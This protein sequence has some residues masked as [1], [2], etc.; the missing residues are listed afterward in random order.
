MLVT[1]RLLSKLSGTCTIS[2]G[3]GRPTN[4]RPVPPLSWSLRGLPSS[5]RSKSKRLVMDFSPGKESE[6][7]LS[8]YGQKPLEKDRGKTPKGDEADLTKSNVFQ[9]SWEIAHRSRGAI[10]PRSPREGDVPL[11]QPANTAAPQ[12]A[13]S[14]RAGFGSRCCPHL[15]PI[16]ARNGPPPPQTSAMRNPG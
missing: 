13:A 10:S 5:T 1:M 8:R 2:E 9:G 12:S 7:Q 15:P 3:R 11:P 16:L 14:P 6:L 4:P